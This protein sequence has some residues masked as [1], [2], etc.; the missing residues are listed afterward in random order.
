MCNEILGVQ[1]NRSGATRSASYYCIRWRVDVG[2]QTCI[3]AVLAESLL[4]LKSFIKFTIE[5]LTAN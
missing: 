2:T 1:R 4:L 3:V 5:D